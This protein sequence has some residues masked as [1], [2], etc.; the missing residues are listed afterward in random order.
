MGD[1]VCFESFAAISNR[2]LSRLGGIRR[3]LCRPAFVCRAGPWAGRPASAL[4]ANRGSQELCIL[5]R[6]EMSDEVCFERVA[7]ISN[8]WVS[9]L[10]GIT[11][12]FCRRGPF[13]RCLGLGISPFDRRGP[14]V[15]LG[16]FGLKGLREG[17]AGRDPFV[18]GRVLRVIRRAVKLCAQHSGRASLRARRGMIRVVVCVRMDMAAVPP[19]RELPAETG[20]PRWSG[21]ETSS[22]HASIERKFTQIHTL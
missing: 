2:C 4:A 7:A 19:R 1:R 6:L 9:R 13:G 18:R 10:E 8:R 15:R 12:P 11:G 17:A 3:A 5:S 16:G 21:S 22:N 14:F 20:S